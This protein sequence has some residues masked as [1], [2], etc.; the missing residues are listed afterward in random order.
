MLTNIEIDDALI[1]RALEATGLK[2]EREVVEEG[3]RT[4]VRLRSQ[5]D[6]L[7]LAGKVRWLGDL[8]ETR[9]GRNAE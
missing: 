8:D 7:G 6:I 3:L 9:R 5:R 4:L 2:N 1:T